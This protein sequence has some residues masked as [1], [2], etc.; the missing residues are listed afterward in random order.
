MILK[1]TDWVIL[2]LQEQS[3]Y[4]VFY[5]L[6]IMWM[7]YWHSPH[8]FGRRMKSFF[9]VF[10]I[11][12]FVCIWKGKFFSFW[13]KYFV[14]CMHTKRELFLLLVFIIWLILST[15]KRFFF[16][17]VIILF[18]IH[19]LKGNFSSFLNFHY[20]VGCMST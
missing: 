14:G 1:L 12:L 11:L 17:V 20:F 13:C 3:S 18:V 6:K 2:T 5:Q 8:V 16:M 19:P 15:K 10:I 7:L 9:F 4:T